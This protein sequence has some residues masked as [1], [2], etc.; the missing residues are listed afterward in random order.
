MGGRGGPLH[1]R[2]R[3]PTGERQVRSAIDRQDCPHQAKKTRDPWPVPLFRGLGPTS[4]QHSSDA[5]VQ[6]KAEEL[7]VE[8][9]QDS[10]G[11]DAGMLQRA[12]N[13][14]PA[15]MDSGFAAVQWEWVN[16]WDGLR[17]ELA[18]DGIIDGTEMQ[19]IDRLIAVAQTTSI[20][21]VAMHDSIDA[22]GIE[23]GSTTYTG[24]A[25]GSIVKTFHGVANSSLDLWWQQL[26][27]GSNSSEQEY[28]VAQGWVD[29]GGALLSAGFSA[30]P[31]Y[32][33]NGSVD[34]LTTVLD[35]AEGAITTSFG[36]QAVGNALKTGFKKFLSWF[37]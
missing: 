25:E 14:V 19:H 5:A 6:A 8:W 18:L 12:I 37:D 2:A 3:G 29:A 22:I 36:G 10:A 31:Q 16:T 27:A 20:N 9:L 24:E 30:A 33:S 32:S 7:L 13:A 21:Y 28:A 34:V 11:L 4:Y 26:N 1:H 15:Y 17:N 35:G 23:I